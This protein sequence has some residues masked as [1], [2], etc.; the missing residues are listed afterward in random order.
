[1][2]LGF[3]I[4]SAEAVPFAASPIVALKLRISAMQP[5]QAIALRVQ[6]RIEPQKRSYL[7]REAAELDE[8]FGL[9]ARFAETL[10]PFLW[11]HA[12]VLVPAFTEQVSVEIHLP[13][14]QDFE[15][16]VTKY[17]HALCDGEIPLLLLFSGTVFQLG[18]GGGLSIAPVP[19]SHEALFRMPVRVLKEAIE[20]HYPNSTA[21]RL[22]RDVFDRLRHFK[23]DR[24]FTTLEQAIEHLLQTAAADSQTDP[25]RRESPR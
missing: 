23:T 3:H 14:S 9:P 7:A 12:S 16:G 18:E 6:V 13:C 19:W 4:E 25:A 11:T 15:L 22:H 21:V 2:K 24:G 1:M 10:R 8:L 5:V 20:Q 17:F